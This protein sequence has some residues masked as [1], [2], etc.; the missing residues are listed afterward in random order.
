MNKLFAVP[1]NSTQ[2]QSLYGYT[3]IG[4]ATGITGQTGAQRQG[5]FKDNSNIE[6]K[7]WEIVLFCASPVHLSIYQGK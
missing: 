6:T 4:D 3:Q 1:L 7:I 5:D 2:L